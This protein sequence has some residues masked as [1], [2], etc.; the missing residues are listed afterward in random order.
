MSTVNGLS[1]LAA[2]LEDA[3]GPAL[4]VGGLLVGSIVRQEASTLSLEL[5][6]SARTQVVKGL[7]K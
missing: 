1:K 2:A 7:F 4:G 3:R 6:V 5:K